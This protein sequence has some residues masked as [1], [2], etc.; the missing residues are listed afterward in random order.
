MQFRMTATV[1]ILLAAFIGLLW[2]MNNWFLEDFYIRYKVQLLENG[3]K[4]LNTAI[5]SAYGTD[6]TDSSS[7]ETYD[8]TADSTAAEASDSTA[9]STVAEA[10]DSTADSS[11]SEAAAAASESA[12]SSTG[13]SAAAE[14]SQSAEALAESLDNFKPSEPDREAD[15]DP[16]AGTGTDTETPPEDETPPNADT[17]FLIGEDGSEDTYSI[18]SDDTVVSTVEQLLETSNISVLIYD[19]MEDKILVSSSAEAYRMLDKMQHYILGQFPPKVQTIKQT[20]NYTIQKSSDRFESKTYLESWGY[21]TDNGTMFFMSVPVDSIR[22]AVKISNQLLQYLGLVLIV[23]GSVA[24]IFMTRHF[25]RP[26]YRLSQLSERMSRLDFNAKY[27]PDSGSTTEIETL[28]NSMNTL[29]DRLNEAIGQLQA[30]NAQLQKDIKEKERIDEMRKEF[31]ADVSHEL[32]TPIALIQGYAEGLVEG[33]A[34]DPEN[35]DY[36]C[37]VIMDEAGKMNKMVKQL[38]TLSALESGR[39]QTEMRAFDIAELI[40]GVVQANQLVIRSKEA[41]V[42][43]DVQEQVTVCGDEF[44]IEEVVTNYLNN[45]LNHVDDRKKIRIRMV[46]KPDAGKVRVLVYNTGKPIPE[47]ELGKLWQK[48]YKVDK[49][50]TRA[51][52]GSGI[53]LSIVKAIMDRHHQAYGVINRED[54]VEFWFELKLAEKDPEM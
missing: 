23:I 4:Q 35:R 12:D 24:S 15:N 47:E 18:T 32:K 52:G 17:P 46:Q 16:D 44:Q 13:Q 28:G 39:V 37:N 26:I 54:G 30:A 3:Y 31:I 40:R 10:S 45:A 22:E 2:V 7:E 34:E 33:M 38:L 51:Y 36:Y 11:A 20:D 41:D 6:E 19:S 8:S 48:F 49:A 9:D 53:G 1:I 25:T 50:R 14:A 43:V 5:V 27:E 21:F 29:S 42:E